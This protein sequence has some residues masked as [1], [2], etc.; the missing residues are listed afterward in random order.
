MH[1]EA[2]PFWLA[3]VEQPWV[4]AAKASTINGV[5]VKKGEYHIT[6][7]YLD[8]E[9]EGIYEFTDTYCCITPDGIQG[10]LPVK[11]LGKYALLAD[12]GKA[13]KQK[14]KAM[15]KRQP[16]KLNPKSEK[17]LLELSSMGSL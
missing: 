3:V 1:D 11:N 12:H 5:Q 10:I 6:G 16:Y 9:G 4:K 13:G 14:G 15:R 8:S 17:Q 7:R 2:T